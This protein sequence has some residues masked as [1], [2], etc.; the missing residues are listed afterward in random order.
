MLN[1]YILKQNW[2]YIIYGIKY[3]RQAKWL[4]GERAST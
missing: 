2:K 1:Y 3:I 4:I